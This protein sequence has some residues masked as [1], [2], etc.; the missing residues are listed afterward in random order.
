MSKRY[1]E[2]SVRQTLLLPP[3]MEDWLPEGH[4][5]RFVMDVVDEI[6]LSPIECVIQ[7]K[8]PRGTRPYS[9]QMMVALLFYAY[10]TGRFSSRRIAR[11]CVED[12]ALRVISR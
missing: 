2:P 7:S 4:L 11:G 8:D 6:D 9:P 5:A 1:R 10:A 3:S 12:V